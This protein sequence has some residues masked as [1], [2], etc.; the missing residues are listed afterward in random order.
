MNILCKHSNYMQPGHCQEYDRRLLYHYTCS[1]N[2]LVPRPGD[3]GYSLLEYNRLLY[4]LLITC[5]RD[6]WS[7]TAHMQ[8]YYYMQ[9][10]CLECA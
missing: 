3:E 8:L 9:P 5:S 10:G 4:E 1:L 2:S 7:M 6:A